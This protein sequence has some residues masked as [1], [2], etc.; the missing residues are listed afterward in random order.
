MSRAFAKAMGEVQRRASI[1]EAFSSSL[2]GRIQ[3]LKVWVL[4]CLLLTT[5]TY[6]PDENIEHSLRTVYKTALAIDSWGV[7]L[8]QLSP[9]HEEGG[10]SLTQPQT[11][12]RVQAGLAITKFI[13]YP[14][15]FPPL[16]GEHFQH[17][18]VKYGVCLHSHAISYLQL[19]LVP[20]KTMGSLARS[21]KAASQAR[22]DVCEETATC[23]PLHSLPLWHSSI[24]EKGNYLTY[25]CPAVI[26]RGVLTA[27]DM[28]DGN[29]CPK[30]RYV[31]FLGSTWASVY[32]QGLSW[33]QGKPR[34]D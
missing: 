31:G 12:L 14:Q 7:R 30:P 19:C 22:R 34:S 9:P 10:Y 23:T 33:L 21:L 5:R 4:P 32:C 25:Y 28:F 15:S 3:L 17:W 11:W 27:R 6:C 16:V 13:T 29:D 24:F 8:K 26:N 2:P 1:L 18:A 20:Y